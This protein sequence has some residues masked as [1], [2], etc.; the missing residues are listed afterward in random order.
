MKN[1]KKVWC[2]IQGAEYEGEWLSTLKIFSSEEKARKYMAEELKS[3]YSKVF[4]ES[5]EIN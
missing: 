3:T 1:K 2:V 4:I 5:R